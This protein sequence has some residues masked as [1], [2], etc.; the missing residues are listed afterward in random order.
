MNKPEDLVELDVNLIN[1][2][3]EMKKRSDNLKNKIITESDLTESY[4]RYV[5]YYTT[6]ITSVIQNMTTI[7]DKKFHI[8]TAIKSSILNYGDFKTKYYSE[9]VIIK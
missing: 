1:S 3:S 5:E 6:R 8:E 2:F 9:Y 4:K 7:E